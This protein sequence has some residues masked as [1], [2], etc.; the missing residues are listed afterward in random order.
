MFLTCYCILATEGSPTIPLARVGTRWTGAQH[1]VSYSTV[2]VYPQ[3][4][5][6]SYIREIFRTGNHIKGIVRHQTINELDYNFFRY[7]NAETIFKI[8]YRYIAN[9]FLKTLICVWKNF[10]N[11][12]CTNSCFVYIVF[13]LSVIC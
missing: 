11:R 7:F 3:N 13:N 10:P 5:T 8:K 1:G 4:K 9:E 12:K 6:K 2:I